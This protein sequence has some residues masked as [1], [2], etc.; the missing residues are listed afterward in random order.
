MSQLDTIRNTVTK[1]REE[2][3]K[4]KEKFSKEQA[5]IPMLQKKIISAKRTINQTQNQSTIKSKLRE[6]EQSN[7]SIADISKNC[8]EVQRKIAQKEKELATAEK[9][10]LREEDKINKKRAA[11]EKRLQEQR[12]QIDVIEQNIQQQV[13]VQNA[14]QLD[15]DRLKAVPDEITVLFLASNPLGTSRLCL[16]EEVRAIQEKIRLSEYRDS[17]HFESRWA[18]RAG[19][20]LQAINETNPTIVHF[21]GHGDEDGNLILT[22]P[23]KSWK[24]VSKEAMSMAIS[25]ASDTVRLVFFNACFS[26]QQAE[27]VVKNIEAAVGMND[28]IGGDTAII[29]A[30]Q[31][32]SSIGFGY[33]LDKSFKQ[34]KA[35]IMLDGISQE[36]IPQIFCRDDV[37]LEEVILV[38]P[39]K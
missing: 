34:A 22:N 3:V 35:A 37:N 30:A 2:L 16:D 15:I 26:E 8:A 25:T 20:I 39:N 32:Y 13:M 4:L 17:L 11:E 18:V 1:K 28:S 27:S 33:S 31:F 29:F 38:N 24:S 12:S 5:K 6:I 23:D 14:M 21:S 36:N 9:N 10:M 19:D 7:K